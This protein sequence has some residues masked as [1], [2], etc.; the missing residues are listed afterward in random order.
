MTRTASDRLDMWAFQVR[1]RSWET[2]HRND[3]AGWVSTA[4]HN[5]KELAC[6]TIEAGAD[7][8]R[9]ALLKELK[10]DVSAS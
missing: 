9:I 3:G 8:S 5:G 6:S 7:Q 4:W 2:V 1:G 10:P